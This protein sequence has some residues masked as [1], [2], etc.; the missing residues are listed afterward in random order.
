MS[1]E[2]EE[3]WSGH[4]ILCLCFEWTHGWWRESGRGR[5]SCRKFWMGWLY[6]VMLEYWTTE[7]FSVHYI[8]HDIRFTKLVVTK[9]NVN[10]LR[11]S[12]S[13]ECYIK[14]AMWEGIT[15]QYDSNMSQCLPLAFVDGH[16]V[17]KANGKLPSLYFIRKSCIKWYE[18]G[19]MVH[20][21]NINQCLPASCEVI[22][23]RGMN[24]R[25]PLWSPVIT[26]ALMTR[27]EHH[28]TNSRVSL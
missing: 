18:R 24:A 25:C 17:C 2:T 10:V 21:L 19:G 7:S 28:S 13:W 16:C 9:K 11:W 15:V 20:I 3:K 27:S 1:T 23:M 22:A 4:Y 6:A 26:V 12:S 8:A 5:R 14:L